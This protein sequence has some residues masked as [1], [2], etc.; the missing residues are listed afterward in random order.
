MKES[1]KVLD[2]AKDLQ[3][4]KAKVYNGGSVKQADYYPHGMASIYD[5]LNTKL[6]RIR[7]ILDQTANNPSYKPE[8]ESLEDSLKD[9]INYASFG[10]S[11]ARGKLEGQNP[12]RDILNRETNAN[13]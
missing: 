12:N 3:I 13:R 2:E 11:Y 7:S 8:Y 1:V 6:L 10:V 9:L 4:S 5:M